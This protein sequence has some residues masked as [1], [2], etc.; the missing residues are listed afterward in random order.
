M[1]EFAGLSIT[2]IVVALA[3]AGYLIDRF[4]DAKG[5][6]RSSKTLRRE[7]EDLVR[8]NTEL[9]QTV[10]RHEEE[11]DRQKHAIDMLNEKVAELEKLN[12]QAV[13]DALKQHETNAAQRHAENA[14]RH[15][16][17]IT[18]WTQIRD[19]LATV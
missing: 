2:E 7:N 12:Q 14:V 11:I 5:W 16:E 9:E 4:L 10:A 6:S 8:R 17:S 15:Q 1:N 3:A 18:V 13:L 19:S